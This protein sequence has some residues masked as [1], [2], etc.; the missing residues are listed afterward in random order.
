MMVWP[1]WGATD[2]IGRGS[3]RG[4]VPLN[5]STTYNDPHRIMLRLM[6]TQTPP[7]TQTKSGWDSDFGGASSAV[8]EDNVWTIC[9]GA[10]GRVHNNVPEVIPEGDD[11][12]HSMAKPIFKALN[13]HNI[14]G[15]GSQRIQES[16][17]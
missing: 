13:T 7:L 14:Q 4:I 2:T 9:G 1:G 10:S 6:S 3:T 16:P 15:E 17:A 8:C 5:K 12:C 11:H